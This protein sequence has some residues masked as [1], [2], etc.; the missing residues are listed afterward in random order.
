MPD[1]DAP[2]DRNRPAAAPLPG[3]PAPG[4]KK[5]KIIAKLSSI[6]KFLHQLCTNCAP[7]VRQFCTTCD[8]IAN[9][10]FMNYAPDRHQV[11]TRW[12]P[13]VPGLGIAFNSVSV[14]SLHFRS[15][16]ERNVHFR[17]F[18]SFWRLMKPPPKNY[19]IVE[20]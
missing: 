3:C 13:I 6:C 5:F 18:S 8:P 1:L 20:I 19:V 12:A 4:K 7:L 15:F 17:S 14:R 11:G 9:E 10:F 2:Y 16:F